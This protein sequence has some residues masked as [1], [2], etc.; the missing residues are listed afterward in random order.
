VI[1]FDPTLSLPKLLVLTVFGVPIGTVEFLEW[2]H[3]QAA[4]Q[5]P[6]EQGVVVRRE[7][8]RRWGGIPAGR[9]HIRIVKNNA[10]VQ[11]QMS[12]SAMLKTPN[13]IQVHYGGNP[14]D[15]VVLETEP[16]PIWLV[17][18]CW[19]L[20]SVLWIMYLALRRNS[21]WKHLVT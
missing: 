13:A 8:F 19:G 5:L 11:A 1:D 15:E 4:Q 12:R 10:V 6:I 2:L 20:V 14:N 9:I 16:K 18:L 3:W 17:L 21:K 7:E